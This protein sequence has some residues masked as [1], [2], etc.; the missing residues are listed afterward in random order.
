MINGKTRYFITA[1]VIVTFIIISGCVS[2]PPKVVPTTQQ[3]SAAPPQSSA[4]NIDRVG[5][6]EG[7]QTSY[8]LF[9]IFD[10]PENKRLLMVYANDN[11]SSI[12]P[13]EPFPYG[14]I[15]AMETYSAKQDAQGNPEK[16]TEG[17]YIKDRLQ[18]ILVMRKEVGFGVDYQT[19]RNDE[20]EY[21]AYHPNKTYLVPPQNTSLCAGCH[22]AAI[23]KDFVFRRDL[24]FVPD[25]YGISPIAGQNEVF[26]SSMAFKPVAL[27]VIP[28]TTVRWVNYDVIAHS[29]VPNDQSF[30]SVVLNPG[31]S[32]NHTFNRVGTFDYVCGVHP[33]LMK[34]RI[35]V[36]E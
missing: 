7:Y 21:A 4:P 12:K 10:I 26:I 18:A 11:A 35:E 25:K 27:Q 33:Q 32:F 19:L 15:L 20:W 3:G 34:A 9:Y 16:N 13:G 28:G 5:F 36:K 30:T 6:P 23:Y 8:K 31:D 2:S 22:L 1:A 17:H 29:M 24:F 14:S